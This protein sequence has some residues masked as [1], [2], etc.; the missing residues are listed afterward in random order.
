V[1]P[2]GPQHE[3]GDDH[4]AVGETPVHVFGE[5]NCWTSFVPGT[6]DLKN[7]FSK[8]FVEKTT[9]CFCKNFIITLVFEKNANFF[10]L[11]WQKLQK[12]V[13]I[14]SPPPQSKGF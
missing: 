3:D 14:T 1:A 10:A 6:D 2:S 8:K 13:I 9:N 11:I 5:M 7:I 4:Q 12:I